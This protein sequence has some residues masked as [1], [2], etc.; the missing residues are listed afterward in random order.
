MENRVGALAF[1]AVTKHLRSSTGSG[2]GLVC[3]TVAILVPKLWDCAGIVHGRGCRMAEVAQVL[4]PGSSK[5]GRNLHVNVPS[6]AYPGLVVV[7]VV[8]QDSNH[9]GG[10]MAASC[11][12]VENQYRAH[13]PEAPCG[14]DWSPGLP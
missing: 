10:V 11:L 9:S 6:R 5:R 8:S 1:S 12:V 3:F 7:V 2:E 4:W 13:Y 14:I